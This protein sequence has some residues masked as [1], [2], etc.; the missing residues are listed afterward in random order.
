MLST[1]AN[2][3]KDVDIHG[4][5]TTFVATGIS[6][7]ATAFAAAVVEGLRM[8]SRAGLGRPRGCN[9]TNL[10]L[11]TQGVDAVGVDTEN[12]GATTL[13]GGFCQRPDLVCVSGEFELDRREDFVE[14]AP[15]SDSI[16]AAA[17]SPM[18]AP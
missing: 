17:P 15:L 1:T 3:A 12:G 4:S 6:R 10:K 2:G 16:S 18:P 8:V 5:G 13:N 11:L 14:Y 7:R 9:A